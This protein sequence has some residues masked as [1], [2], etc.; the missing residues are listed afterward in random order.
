[1]AVTR[2]HKLVSVHEEVTLN[3]S[4]SWA[5]NGKVKFEWLLSDGR[6]ATSPQ[7]TMKYNRPGHYSEPLKVTDDQGHVSYDFAVTQVL[8]PAS[9]EALPPSIQASFWPSMGVKTSTP[10]TF[11]TRTFRTT[12]G[13]ETWNFGD[14]T[15]EVTVKSDGNSKTL[16][17]D[18]FAAT[19]HRFS[20][21]GDYLVKVTR[22]NKRG[23]S[24]TAHLHV[25]VEEP[26][27]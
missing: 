7:V 4:R 25:H 27:K 18:G 15:S 17:P 9:P 23:E 24:A 14:G 5:R 26:L 8:D 20:S 2:P 11:L 12:E 19:V 3:G 16:A 6:M 13:A 21:P 1:M 10:V 22:T